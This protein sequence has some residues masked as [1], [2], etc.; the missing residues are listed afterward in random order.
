MSTPL[1]CGK[2]ETG[3]RGRARLSMSESGD[4]AVADTTSRFLKS[5]VL[6]VAACSVGALSAAAQMPFPPMGGGVTTTMPPG[7][8]GS[9][10]MTMPPPGGAPQQAA[11]PAPVAPKAAVA[12]P[13]PKPKPKPVT[14]A[15][16]EGAND[17][18]KPGQSI[19]MLVNDEPITAYEVDMRTRFLAMSSG[20]ADI[21][22]R[23]QDS[24]KALATNEGVNARFRATVE[25]L[26]KENQGKKSREEIMKMIEAKKTE[27]AQGLQRQALDGARSATLPKFRKDAQEELVEEKLKMQEARKLGVGVGDEEVNRLIK[28]IAERNKLTEA[29]FAANIKNGGSDISVMKA[30]FQSALSWREVVRRKFAAQI[31]VNQ[32]DVDK[33]LANS[34]SGEAVDTQ[35]L[36]IQKISLLLPAKIDQ[37]SLAQRQAD[38]DGLRRRFGGCKTT[39]QLAATLPGSK[40]EDLKFI[41]PSSVGEPTRSF[42]T[43]AKDGEMIPPQL[44]SGSLDIYTVCGRRDLKVDEK[45][46]EEA[47][48]EL[49]SREFETLATRYLR[50]LK[51]DALCMEPG[52]GGRVDCSRKN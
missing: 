6:V 15:S 45:K 4:F 2:P 21:A 22:K 23:A 29:Q 19:V 8:G 25:N 28:G 37:A 34:K 27:F 39:G 18:G 3:Q 44:G 33:F 32:R 26:I 40:F 11:Q 35:E 9:V 16:T 1:L 7:S 24:F 46:R 48:Q 47:Q 13:K 10:V 51:Q 17:A 5:T 30:R 12:A 20:G 49:Q 52:S 41:R 43:S 50:D 14:T 31:S 42:L 36:Q 38:A